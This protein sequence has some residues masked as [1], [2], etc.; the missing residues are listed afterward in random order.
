M[1]FRQKRFYVDTSVWRDYLEDR[2]DG[3][4]PLGLFAFKFFHYCKK[5]RCKVLYSSHMLDEFGKAYSS[6]RIQETM[7]L[8]DQ[9]LLQQVIVTKDAIILAVD[10]QKQGM[11]KEDALHA[12]LAIVNNAI[13]VSRDKHFK[14]NPDLVDGKTPEEAIL[15]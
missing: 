5:H 12:A 3:L 10:L 15:D 8:I 2:S 14:E 4:R 1:L 13:L 11:H 9:D 6:E 7:G